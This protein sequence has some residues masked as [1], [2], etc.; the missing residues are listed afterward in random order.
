MIKMKIEIFVVKT[1]IIKNVGKKFIRLEDK[2]DSEKQNL[3]KIFGGMTIIPNC[4]GYWLNDNDKVEKD[5]VETWIIYVNDNLTEKL[6]YETVLR[7]DIEEELKES[8]KR[9]KIATQQKTQAY[10]IDNKIYFI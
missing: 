5:F 7:K 6:E 9:I 10:A 1:E 4:H 2:L 8:L 3:T